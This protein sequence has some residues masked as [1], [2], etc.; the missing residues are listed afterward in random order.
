MCRSRA[1]I[2]SNGLLKKK[3]KKNKDSQP[4]AGPQPAVGSCI[5]WQTFDAGT[6]EAATKELLSAFNAQMQIQKS[7]T[8]MQ[9]R[10]LDEP[11]VLVALERLPAFSLKFVPRA[12]GFTRHPDSKPA[13]AEYDIRLTNGPED[14]FFCRRGV[15]SSLGR[16]VDDH[17]VIDVAEFAEASSEN[18]QAYAGGCVELER[19]FS[20]VLEVPMCVYGTQDPNFKPDKKAPAKLQ[21][22]VAYWTNT[23]EVPQGAAIYIA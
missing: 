6:I 14:V 18:A 20:G 4:P 17:L 3:H 12:E 1:W 2:F 13:E 11:R 9:L 16:M 8:R 7:P 23:S 22:T 21:L 15:P 5:E 19:V 10:M